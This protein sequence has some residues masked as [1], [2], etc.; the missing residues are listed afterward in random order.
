MLAAAVVDPDHWLGAGAQSRV[1]VLLEGGTVYTPLKLDQGTNVAR[2]AAADELLVAG[3]LWAENRKQ[4][5]FKP[6]VMTQ[7]SGR[8]HLI[9][10]TQDPTARGFQRGMDVLFLNAVFR[11]AAHADPVR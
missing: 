1:N 9:A 5:A 6:L 10:F 3:H 4:L 8:G 7:E 2:F 11:G